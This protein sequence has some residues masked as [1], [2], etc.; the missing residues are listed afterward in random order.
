MLNSY[1]IFYDRTRK[2]YNFNTVDCFI[3]VTT[4]AGLTVKSNIFP[5]DINI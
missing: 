2:M 5:F 3:E 4:W 1:E